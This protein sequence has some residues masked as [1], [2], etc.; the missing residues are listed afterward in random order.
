VQYGVDNEQVTIDEKTG[1]AHTKSLI[2]KDVVERYNAHVNWKGEVAEKFWSSPLG[3][4]REAGLDEYWAEKEKA[5]KDA[6]EAAKKELRDEWAKGR[7]AEKQTDQIT[8]HFQDNFA[9]YWEVDQATKQAK[10]DKGGNYV[11]TAEYHRLEAAL[12]IGKQITGLDSASKDPEER[13]KAYQLGLTIAAGLPTGEAK[14]PGQATPPVVKP[15]P[16]ASPPFLR[17]IDRFGPATSS[18]NG[19]SHNH[20]AVEGARTGDPL[21]GEG[22]DAETLWKHLGDTLPQNRGL[23]PSNRG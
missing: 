9:K 20:L 16:A 22:L 1:L 6:V 15:P 17:G 4:L 7:S 8:Q 21:D 5:Y 19:G 23:I 2:Y 3:L 18:E 10:T 11:P 13:L 12:A 14:P